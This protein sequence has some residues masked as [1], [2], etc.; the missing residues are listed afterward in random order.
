M[1]RGGEGPGGVIQMLTCADG[2][3]VGVRNGTEYADVILELLLLLLFLLFCV[4]MEV[5]SIT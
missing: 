3:E 5:Q 1:A 4:C 2:G